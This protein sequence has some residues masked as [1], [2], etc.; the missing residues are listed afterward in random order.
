LQCKR[1]E[2]TLVFK[3]RNCVER[4]FAVMF[5]V[6][7]RSS[8][9]ALVLT[10][11][12]VLA[13]QLDVA[14]IQFAEAKDQAALESALSEI[15]LAEITDSDRTRTSVPEL[16]NG[17]VLFSQSFP[18]SQGSRFATSTRL[19]NTRA[20]V[21]GSLSGGALDVAIALQEGVQAG[22]RNFQ[23][24]NY[25]G[26]AALPSGPASLIS[27]RRVQTSAPSVVKGQSTPDKQAY[28]IILVAQFTP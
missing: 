14:V 13:G 3:K 27:I 26:R 9:L 10:V 2:A 24:R 17:S 20:D 8:L 11:C 23:K 19:G 16:K 4:E 15:R 6:M 12:P 28:T 18:A 25:A 21:E 1:V 5:R 22:L 7:I